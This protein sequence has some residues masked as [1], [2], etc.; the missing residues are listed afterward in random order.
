MKSLCRVAVVARRCLY[1]SSL[2]VLSLS[3]GCSSSG[4]KPSTVATITVSPSSSSIAVG[5]TQQFSA[6]AKDSSGNTISGVT[7]T[8]ASSA[9]NVATVNSSGLATGVSAGTSQITASASGVTSSPDALTVTTPP[10]ATITVSPSAPS[11]A[12]GATQQFTATA[13]DS[14]G[15][16]LS[17]VIFAWASSATG[18]ATINSSGLATA[19]SAGTTEITASA[20]GI[21]SSNDTLTVTSLSESLLNGSYVFLLKGFDSS[22]N[23]ALVMGALTFDG[24]GTITAGTIDM[25]LNSGVES[26]LPVTSGTYVIGSDQRG[27]MVITTSAGT[28]NYRFSVGNISGGI[29]STGHMIDFDKAGP[30]TAGILW[31]PLESTCRHASLSI[32]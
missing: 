9:T 23:P 16:T 29:A 15:N 5:A 11:I 21:T 1:L 22:G 3:M 32:L 20:N 24:M 8:W 25:N 13:K 26:N 10:V 28:Q 14:N 7:F 27:S 2:G 4:T 17:G 12:V 18:V 19:V 30:F 31:D 6:S